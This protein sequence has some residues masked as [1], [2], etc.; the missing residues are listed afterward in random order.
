[1]AR[2][3]IYGIQAVRALVRRNWPPVAS[4]LVETGLGAERRQRLAEVLQANYLVREVTHEEL[5][6][7][8]GTPKH[9]GVVAIVEDTGPLGEAEAR[10]HVE[11]IEC[12]L[13]LVLDS[14]RDPRNLGACLRTADAAGVDLVVAGR[15]RTVGM[16][17]VVSKVAAGAAETQ[18]LAWVSNLS[19]FLRFL[20]ANRVWLVGADAAAARGLYE[21]DLSGPLAIVLGGEG[22]GLRRLTRERCD[23]LAALPM[24]GG[25]ESLNVSVAAGVCLYEALRQR[26][27]RLA[28]QAGL[29]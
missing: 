16:T 1:M 22:E 4:I 13:I 15:S 26:R 24:L 12:P 21:L 23:E 10:R 28:P 6:A 25:V 7:L 14:I 19:R 20:A 2:R 18:P 3:V 27:A 9:Q 8:T 29:R 5:A 17:P 11:T